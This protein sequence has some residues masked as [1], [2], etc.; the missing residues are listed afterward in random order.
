MTLRDFPWAPVVFTTATTGQR[1]GAVLRAAA[2]VGEQHGR[3][4]GTGTLNAVVRDALAWKSPPVKGGRA[5]RVYYGA[6]PRAPPNEQLH[7]QEPPT[8]ALPTLPTPSVLLCHHFPHFAP[9]F[10]PC[11]RAVTQAA[12]RPPTFVL[13][14]NDPE[15][16]GEG[17]RRYIER[18]LRENIGFKGT[19]LRVLMRGKARA[20]G[21]ADRDAAAER[22]AAAA[23]T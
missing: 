6:P 7:G 10:F 1:V 21:A 18:A 9:F 23:A 15:L 3:R 4:V 16:F 5:G 2:D 12:T 22:K 19:P 13:F 11:A 14:V 17:Y 20:M 8:D